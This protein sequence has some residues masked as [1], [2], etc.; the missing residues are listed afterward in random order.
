MY[1]FDINFV[2]FKKILMLFSKIR[3]KESFVMLYEG[4]SYH[5]RISLDDIFISQ[6][7]WFLGV[8]FLTLKLT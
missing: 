6:Q 5:G 2:K 8:T 4:R 7:C 1:Y 3:R